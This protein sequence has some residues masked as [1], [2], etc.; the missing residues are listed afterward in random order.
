MKRVIKVAA[1]ILL[2]GAIAA[3]VLAWGPGR[4][5][6]G[7][8]AYER[9]G[10][11]EYCTRYSGYKN[12]TPE[13]REQLDAVHKKFYD[14]TVQLRNDLRIKRAEL[15]AALNTTTPDVEKAKAFQK[16]ISDLQAAMAQKRIDL[17][18]EVRKINP[19]ARYGQG[20]GRGHG[21]H[22]KDDDNG[23]GGRG[24]MRGGSGPGSCWN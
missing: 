4:N 15:N 20:Y 3:P 16:E 1:I 19:D 5:K 17:E 8:G 24:W 13:Q 11:D 9:G 23:R 2:T 6:S 18:V 14:E 7:Q 22:M 21:R 12:L 10:G